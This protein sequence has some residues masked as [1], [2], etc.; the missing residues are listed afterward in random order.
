VVWCMCA[1]GRGDDGGCGGL[2]LW[3]GRRDDDRETRRRGGV[4]QVPQTGYYSGS[5]ISP[6]VALSPPFLVPDDLLA[7]RLLTS[8]PSGWD[9]WISRR[10]TTLAADKSWLSDTPAESSVSIS[11]M[12]KQAGGDHFASAGL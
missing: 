6:S 3:L 4:R 10:Q 1:E 7:I 11:S 9:A 12:S 5:F 8:S 2:W